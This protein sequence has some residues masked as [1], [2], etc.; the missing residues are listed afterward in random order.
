DCKALRVE[1]RRYAERFIDIQR[2]EFRRLGIFGRWDRPY[3]TMDPSYE[4]TIVRVLAHFAEQ[5]YLYRG[6]KPVHWCTS[7]RTALAEA[8]VEYR[9]KSSPS[10]YVAFPIPDVNNT[11]I[12]IWTTTP[13]TLPANQAIALGPKFD[14]VTVKDKHDRRYIVAEQL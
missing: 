11:A 3:R 8:E 9:E 13:W 12:V 2:R 5:G 1:C 7:C 10:I 14:Y 4:A 6:K